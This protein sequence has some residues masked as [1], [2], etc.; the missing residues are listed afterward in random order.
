[1]ETYKIINIGT[2]KYDRIKSI[3]I[4]KKELISYGINYTIKEVKELF[5]YF[6]SNSIE[7]NIINIEYKKSLDLIFNN[8]EYE[9]IYSDY[10]I[11]R[12]FPENFIPPI[13]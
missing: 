8:I 7:D 12:N 4:L 2:L 1:M 6:L 10:Y 3:S 11:E 9:I 5:D 13:G